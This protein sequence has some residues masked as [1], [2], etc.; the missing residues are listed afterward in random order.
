M[1]LS[2]ILMEWTTAN[3]A[4]SQLLEIAA[5]TALLLTADGRGHQM[6]FYNGC[7]QMPNADVLRLIQTAPTGSWM[8]SKS[9]TMALVK[10]KIIKHLL[11]IYGM[12]K[13]AISSARKYLAFHS[14][15]IQDAHNIAWMI[16][17]NIRECLLE[18]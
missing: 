1:A 10:L 8:I 14:T 17:L 12:H 9:S 4:S 6:T 7:L 15:W 3:L 11:T 13:C 18:R 2:C 5:I 16:I